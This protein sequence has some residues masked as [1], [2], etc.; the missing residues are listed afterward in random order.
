M[1]RCVVLDA[2]RRFPWLS[3]PYIHVLEMTRHHWIHN[4]ESRDWTREY[5]LR[6]LGRTEG[7]T[8]LTVKAEAD[9]DIDLKIPALLLLAR[10]QRVANQFNSVMTICKEGLEVIKRAQEQ[11]D[12]PVY[13]SYWRSFILLLAE[14]FHRAKQL[15]NAQVTYE[16][17]LKRDPNNV[18]ALK[19]SQFRW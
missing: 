8:L 10:V 16:T 18:V 19:V 15:D 11:Y 3:L 2:H 13:V 6:L 12:V 9:S 7:N 5:L 1:E 14:S 17:V 4:T